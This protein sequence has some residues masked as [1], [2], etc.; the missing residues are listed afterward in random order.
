MAEVDEKDTDGNGYVVTSVTR[1]NEGHKRTI[2]LAEDYDDNRFMMRK[3]LELNGYRVVEAR[4]GSEAVKAVL[5][6]EPDLILMDLGLPRVNGIEA[7]RRIRAIA[8][9]NGLPIIAVTAYSS[10]AATSA[11]MEAG[12]DEC[13]TKPVDLNELEC[14]MIELLAA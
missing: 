7:T 4:D 14:M 6:N 9:L 5:S 3:W 10:D 1:R 13:V 11:A 2:V 12:C 8:A